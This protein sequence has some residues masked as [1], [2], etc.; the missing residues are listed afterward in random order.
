MSSVDL[1]DEIFFKDK[2]GKDSSQV[3]Y[4]WCS[5]GA[6][7]SKVITFCEPFGKHGQ[8][9]THLFRFTQDNIKNYSDPD[10]L[11]SGSTRTTTALNST[12][13]NADPNPVDAKFLYIKPWCKIS[14]VPLDNDAYYSPPIVKERIATIRLFCDQK[15]NG[16]QGMPLWLILL[17]IFLVLTAV[18]TAAALFWRYW[19]RRRL[20]GPAPD[21]PRSALESHI[22]S[23]PFSSMSSSRAPPTTMPSMTSSNRSNSRSRVPTT[24]MPS[25]AISNRSNSRSR[26]PN[27]SIPSVAI[28]N[29]SNS[30]GRVPNSI[31]PSTASGNRPNSRSRSISLTRSSRR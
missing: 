11:K 15:L 29:R 2:C 17:I 1:L 18:I 16:V 24:V 12:T 27:S 6:V 28:S 13:P 20:Y 26:A 23:A 5:A 25:L 9:C 10:P 3:F 8:N 31:M 7:D 21:E 22:T 19:L 4:G 30:G 14:N